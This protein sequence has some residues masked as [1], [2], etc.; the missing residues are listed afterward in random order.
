MSQ[1]LGQPM[2]DLQDGVKTKGEKDMRI[3]QDILKLTNLAENYSVSEL[4]DSCLSKNKKKTRNHKEK[5]H[6]CRLLRTL[7]TRDCFGLKKKQSAIT[8]ENCIFLG[9]Y[10]P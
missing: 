10:A 5:L 2:V 1:A 3:L 6:I 8:S 4:I 9:C 7:I